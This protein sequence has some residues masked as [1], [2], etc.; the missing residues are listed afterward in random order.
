MRHSQTIFITIAAT[1]LF[2][3]ERAPTEL[4]LITP[5][6]LIDQAIAEDFAALLDRNSAVKITL[7]P[8]PD[9]EKTVLESLATGNGDIAIVTNIMPFTLKSFKIDIT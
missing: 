3:C 5:K 8:A 6:S 1:L 9:D 7:V 4:R 2:G